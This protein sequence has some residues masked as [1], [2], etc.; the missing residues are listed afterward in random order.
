[1]SVFVNE[2]SVLWFLVSSF[3]R[4]MAAKNAIVCTVLPSPEVST[5]QEQQGVCWVMPTDKKKKS[6]GSVE[7]WL[8]THVIPQ[9]AAFV[10]F[11]KIVQKLNTLPLV[12]VK[13]GIDAA[14]NL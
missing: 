7:A 13:L 3:L 2:V 4:M 5:K 1:M 9:N 10:F 14:W 12:L 11:V 8:G 6:N